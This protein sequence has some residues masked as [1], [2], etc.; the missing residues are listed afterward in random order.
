MADEPAAEIG[1]GGWFSAVVLRWRSRRGR[2]RGDASRRRR[3]DGVRRRRRGRAERFVARRT[4]RWCARRF[5]ASPRRAGAVDARGRVAVGPTKTSDENARVSRRRRGKGGGDRGLRRAA[6]VAVSVAAATRPAPSYADGA[7]PTDLYARGRNA[8]RARWSPWRAGAATACAAWSAA[9]AAVGAGD[10]QARRWRRGGGGV[11]GGGR[12]SGRRRSR[13]AARRVASCPS[14]LLSATVSARKPLPKRR[15]ARRRRG[16]RAAPPPPPAPA[17]RGGPRSA[18]PPRRRRLTA[19]ELEEMHSIGNRDRGAREI[20][21]GSRRDRGVRSAPTPRACATA[22]RLSPC[23]S[24]IAGRP[25]SEP[26]SDTRVG[27]L[28]RKFRKRPPSLPAASSASA[29]NCPDLPQVTLPP[30]RAVSASSR[31]ARSPS[32]SARRAVALRPRRGLLAVLEP[33][34]HHVAMRPPSL[35]GPTG[36]SLFPETRRLLARLRR[37]LRLVRVR[38]VAVVE[39]PRPWS[40]ERGTPRRGARSCVPRTS[41][42]SPPPPIGAPRSA[43]ASA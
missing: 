41:S 30:S 11:R 15:G 34:A 20:R 25:A 42:P 31:P 7:G 10:V 1:D 5:P 24:T 13:N 16:G 28:E 4:G 18:A 36:S 22:N 12:R 39:E 17:P 23:G 6:A 21:A 26:R 38:R 40:P 37:L 29:W 32:T 27:H 43:T 33:R 35:A 9:R 3:P 14:C 2:R 19:A 8:L